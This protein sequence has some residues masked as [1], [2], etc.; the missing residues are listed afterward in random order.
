MRKQ[1]MRNHFGMTFGET[2]AF[3]FIVTCIVI[4]AQNL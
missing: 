4:V 1:P 3:A 2:M